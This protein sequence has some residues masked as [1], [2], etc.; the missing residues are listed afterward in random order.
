MTPSIARCVAKYYGDEEFPVRLSYMGNTFINNDSY[1]GRLKENT[2]MQ[3]FLQ[4]KLSCTFHII[5]IP[6]S[7]RCM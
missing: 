4:N 2:M 5:D 6:D 3:T 1:Q 7:F